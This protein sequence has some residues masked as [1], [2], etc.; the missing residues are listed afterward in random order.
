MKGYFT[1]K[2]SFVAEVTFNHPIIYQKCDAMMNISTQ[3]RVHF[4]IYLLNHNSLRHQTWLND[5]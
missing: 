5:R 4:Y 1:A 2:T 3:D